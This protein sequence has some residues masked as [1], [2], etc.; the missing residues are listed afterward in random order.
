MKTPAT[1]SARQTNAGPPVMEITGVFCSGG[2]GGGDRGAAAAGEAPVDDEEDRE[3]D[4]DAGRPHG[5][6]F[7]QRPL[8]RDALEEPEVEGRVADGGEAAGAVGDDEDEQDDVDGPQATG[9]HAHERAD[10]EHRGAGRADDIGEHSAEGEQ[11]GVGEGR[12]ARVDVDEDAA[13]DDEEPADEGDEGVVLDERVEERV[14]AVGAVGDEVVAGDDAAE[15]EGEVGVVAVPEVR[16]DEGHQGDARE[17]EGEGRAK[18]ERDGRGGVVVRRR[19]VGVV[20]GRRRPGGPD[21]VSPGAGVAVGEPLDR[22]SGGEE[23]LDAH[24]A[25]VHIG[26]GRGGGHEPAPYEAQPDPDDSG[27][28][29]ADWAVEVTDG[30]VVRRSFVVRHAVR[31]S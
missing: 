21:F 24:I 28:D 20:L 9:V 31:L 16:V 18:N 22:F 5:P 4:A 30:G 14:A 10:K 12:R 27:K 7:E 17:Q 26:G 8:E 19:G 2:G 1:I 15:E 29:P 6:E 25:G 3:E 13:G 11:E 23:L